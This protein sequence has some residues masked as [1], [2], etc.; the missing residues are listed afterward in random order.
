M[1]G[2]IKILFFI[3]LVL[4][5]F[6]YSCETVENIRFNAKIIGSFNDNKPIEN[7]I[8]LNQYENQKKFGNTIGVNPF[9]YDN[10]IAATKIYY[11]LVEI[12]FYEDS[13]KESKI[14]VLSATAVDNNSNN[15]GVFVKKDELIKYWES[16]QNVGKEFPKLKRKIESI[17]LP[18]EFKIKKNEKKT[19]YFVFKSI[20][21]FDEIEKFLI[22][23]KI[24]YND[25]IKIVKTEIT[26]ENS[27]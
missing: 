17:Y 16:N 9:L 5:I 8:Y 24:S 18:D 13:E 11:N 4:G 22:T 26:K 21:S 6:F 12:S 19:Y 7:L 1:K 20:Q 23:I 3:L 25:R 15:I 2:K 14:D 10:S 27:K